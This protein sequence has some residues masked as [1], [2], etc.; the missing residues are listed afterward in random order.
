[1]KRHLRVM[2]NFLAYT[3]ATMVLAEPSYSC[4]K[5][6]IE[7]S[8]YKPTNII[9]LGKIVGSVVRRNG[10]IYIKSG[11][12]L[13]NPIWPENTYTFKKTNFYYDGRKYNYGSI[14]IFSGGEIGSLALEGG[15]IV[16]RCSKDK[17][18][19]LIS[20]IRSDRS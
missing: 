12:V 9:P 4:T 14:L 5:Q 20:E 13:Y 18:N 1:M 3:V 10:C 17:V 16:S 11:S 15:N 6:E 7:I 2:K 8:T 19:F